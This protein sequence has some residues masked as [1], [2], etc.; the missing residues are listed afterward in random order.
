MK[1]PR[2]G[3]ILVTGRSGSGKSTMCS[4]LRRWNIVAFDGDEIEG[5]AGWTDLKSG[6]R[7][8]VDYGRLIDK[9]YLGW[10]WDETVLSDFLANNPTSVLCG[11]ADNQ[12]E[13]YTLFSKVIVLDVTPKEQIRRINNRPDGGYGKAKGMTEFIA[14]EQAALRIRSAEMGAIIL[15]ANRPPEEIARDIRQLLMDNPGDS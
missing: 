3:N 7:V 6:K 13:F 14:R 9:R 11:S 12:T 2:P 8:D 4:I 1:V 15:N 10:L 5:L